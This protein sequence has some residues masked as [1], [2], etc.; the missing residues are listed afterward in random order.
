MVVRDGRRRIPGRRLASLRSVVPRPRLILRAMAAMPTVSPVSME[1]VHQRARS[2][3]QV[4]PPAIQVSAVLRPQEEK[5]HQRKP[6][7]YPSE[8]RAALAVAK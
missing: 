8:G 4:W 1:E 2:K 7:E 6:G 5:G 3:Q